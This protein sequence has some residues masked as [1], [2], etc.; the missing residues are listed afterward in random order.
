MHDCEDKDAVLLHNG[1]MGM[2]GFMLGS[3]G[4]QAGV[5][6]AESKVMLLFSQQLYLLLTAPWRVKC[7]VVHE[8]LKWG[9]RSCFI[10]IVGCCSV[11]TKQ[12][13]EHVKVTM[14]VAAAGC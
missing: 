1:S 13:I 12:K 6:K 4:M 2:Q 5:F 7:C 10:P 3:S 9:S 11:A 8:G 14:G